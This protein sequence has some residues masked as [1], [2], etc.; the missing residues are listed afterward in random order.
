MLNNQMVMVF[1][2]SSYPLT[3]WPGI[4]HWS[5]AQWCSV[6]RKVFNY[7]LFCV[8]KRRVSTA[9]RLVHGWFMVMKS[10][11]SYGGQLLFSLVWRICAMFETWFV[12]P[13]IPITG[14]VVGHQSHWTDRRNKSYKD[15]QCGIDEHPPK[16]VLTMAHTMSSTDGYTI[17]DESWVTLL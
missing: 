8:L 14:T 15:S 5:R 2:L 16:C 3:F 12:F 1:V 13:C 6:V 11:Y 10:G 7:L 9:K 4:L 17:F